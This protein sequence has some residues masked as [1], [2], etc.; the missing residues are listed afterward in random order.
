MKELLL[1]SFAN[2]TELTTGIDSLEH[3]LDQDHF[4]NFNKEISYHYN[5]MGYRDAEWPADLSNQIWCVGDSFTVGLGQPFEEI[6]PQIIQQQIDQRT[7]NV[8]MNGA[9]NDWIARRS[10]FILNNFK[11]KAVLILWSY[12]HRRENNNTDLTDEERAQHYDPE[13][14]HDLLNFEKNLHS[15]MKTDTAQCTVHS[16]IPNA[17]TV[18]SLYYYNFVRSWEPNLKKDLLESILEIND[19][20]FFHSVVP[21]DKARDF[22]HYGLETSKIVAKNY[23]GKIFP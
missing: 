3:C 12:L 23:I 18:E 15:I 6:W 22:H 11:P 10:N 5:S 8:S 9:S 13:D 21:I 17:H 19:C 2:K 16:F 20:N 7:I 4:L 14:C 1:P